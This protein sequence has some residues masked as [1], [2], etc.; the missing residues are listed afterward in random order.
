MARR[1]RV[2][3]D[4]AAW[5]KAFE[6]EAK[7]AERAAKATRAVTLVRCGRH[8]RASVAARR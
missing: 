6:A 4:L 7:R 5:A 2:E 3:P 8:T 1:K